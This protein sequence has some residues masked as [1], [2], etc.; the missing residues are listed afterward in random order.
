MT[1]RGAEAQL[2]LNGLNTAFWRVVCS[3]PG[4]EASGPNR[5]VTLAT[6]AGESPQQMLEMEGFRLVPKRAFLPLSV[7]GQGVGENGK[8]MGT[9]G[10]DE[11]AR[12]VQHEQLL[13][14]I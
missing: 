5:G 12:A 6:P 3:Y 8:P 14:G 11:R 1:K 10:V 9:C 4:A 13:D 2:I 7:G